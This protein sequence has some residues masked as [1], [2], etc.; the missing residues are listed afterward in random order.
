[1]RMTTGFAGGLLTNHIG[2]MVA[3]EEHIANI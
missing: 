3:E 2:K 1:M